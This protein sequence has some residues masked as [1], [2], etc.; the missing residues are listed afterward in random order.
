MC[1]GNNGVANDLPGSMVGDV[2][3]PVGGM[4]GDAVL[5]ECVLVPEEVLCGVFTESGGENRIMLGKNEGI[6]HTVFATSQEACFLLLQGKGVRGAS[7]I[8]DLDHFE[9]LFFWKD[10]A[11]TNNVS[12]ASRGRGRRLILKDSGQGGWIDLR[13][14]CTAGSAGDHGSGVFDG[15]RAFVCGDHPESFA[16]TVFTHGEGEVAGIEVIHLYPAGI[17]AFFKLVAQIFFFIED[18]EMELVAYLNHAT[19]F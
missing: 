5:L 19:E 3:A 7:P 16:A 8:E 11:T 4:E 15:E 9:S 2:A 17:L 14:R 12:G 6:V 1:D 10:D 13:F 18:A